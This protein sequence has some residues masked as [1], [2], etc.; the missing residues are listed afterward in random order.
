MRLL[1][2]LVPK[3]QM[4]PC[5]GPTGPP[6]AT[7]CPPSSMVRIML[8]LS[9]F[10]P[11]NLLALLLNCCTQTMSPGGRITDD[12]DRLLMDTYAERFYTQASNF[13]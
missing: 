10:S 13:N 4:P 5:T 8:P 2:S 6:Y 1:P 12:F 3:T 9:A 7:W 11:R